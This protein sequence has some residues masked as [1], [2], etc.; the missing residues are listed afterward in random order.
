MRGVRDGPIKGPLE[1]KSVPLDSP[2]YVRPIRIPK[3]VV[4]ER[5]D[6]LARANFRCQVLLVVIEFPEFRLTRR[7]MTCSLTS[8]GAQAKRE[9]D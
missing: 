5:V 9:P 7:V 3:K 6:T 1:P 4:E 8:R 2:L